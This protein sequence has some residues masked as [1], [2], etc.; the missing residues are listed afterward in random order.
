MVF[1]RYDHSEIVGATKVSIGCEVLH[2]LTH[3][4]KEFSTQLVCNW[5]NGCYE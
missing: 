3:A 2:N 5:F 1:Q 4:A